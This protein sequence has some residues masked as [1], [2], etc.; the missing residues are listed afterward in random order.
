MCRIPAG[1]YQ[2]HTRSDGHLGWR[3]ELEGVPGMKNIQIHRGNYPGDTTGCI[4]VGTSRGTNVVL[5]SGDAMDLLKNKV[6]SANVI[7]VTIRDPM[8][9]GSGGGGGW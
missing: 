9:G 7:T 2:A 3:I 4:L 8:Q 1:T 5:N 6:G